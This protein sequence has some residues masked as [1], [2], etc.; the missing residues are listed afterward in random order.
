MT[1]EQ[2]LKAEAEIVAIERMLENM[3]ASELKMAY[4]EQLQAMKLKLWNAK[5]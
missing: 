3:P 4:G 1:N 5:K 2:I